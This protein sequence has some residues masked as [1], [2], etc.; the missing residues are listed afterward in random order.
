MRCSFG[1]GFLFCNHH[2]YR[3]LVKLFLPCFFRWVVSFLATIVN[4]NLQHRTKGIEK[5]ITQFWN[6]IS[7]FELQ[8]ADHYTIE[9]TLVQGMLTLCEVA[10]LVRFCSL[11]VMVNLCL[12]I[13]VFFFFRWVVSFSAK[14]VNFNVQLRTKD[15]WEKLNLEL[16]WGLRIHSPRY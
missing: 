13:G 4:S 1:C 15:I 16:N 8:D 7:C 10:S 9:P 12:L 6:R 5:R 3:L 2:D 14:I 11:F